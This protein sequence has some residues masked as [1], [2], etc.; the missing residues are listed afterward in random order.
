MKKEK[1]DEQLKRVNSILA[2]RKRM[3]RDQQ[4]QL[5]KAESRGA[6]DALSKMIQTLERDIDVLKVQQKALKRGI[7]LIEESEN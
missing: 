6:A 7:V 4:K 1:A 5:T 3:L 2:E